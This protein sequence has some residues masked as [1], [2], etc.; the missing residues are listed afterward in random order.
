MK[1]TTVSVLFANKRLNYVHDENSI[2]LSDCILYKFNRSTC[3]VSSVGYVVI[4][5]QHNN[6][7]QLCVFM[8]PYT[9]DIN[10]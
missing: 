5:I 3:H 7:I 8:H 10:K 2:Y 4:V 1:V 9:V 6:N